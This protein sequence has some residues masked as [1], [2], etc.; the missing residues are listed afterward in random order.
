M[1]LVALRNVRGGCCVHKH[2]VETDH[3]QSASG[4]GRLTFE[5]PERQKETEAFTGKADSGEMVPESLLLRVHGAKG[6]IGGCQ[7]TRRAGGAM[8]CPNVSVN[9]RL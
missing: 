9:L 2:G 1:Q 4:M 7:L 8:N 6:C 5:T 3:G